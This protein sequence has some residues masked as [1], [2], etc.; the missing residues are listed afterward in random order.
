MTE[1]E[2]KQHRLGEFLDRHALDGVFL[3][4]RN[5]FAWITCGR[6]NHIANHSPIGVAA[7]LATRDSK[8][9][10]FTN[11]IEAPRFAQEELDGTEIE[12]VSY[13][14]HDAKLGRSMLRDLIAAR[15]IAADVNDFADLMRPLPDEFSQ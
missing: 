9:V 10:C 1:L 6:D 14:W 3:Q 2:D 11:T 8:R 7:I 13:T 15:K 4:R 12:V 5:N